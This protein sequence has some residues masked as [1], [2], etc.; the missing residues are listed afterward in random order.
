[1]SSMHMNM[2]HKRTHMYIVW[3]LPIHKKTLS[4]VSVVLPTRRLPVVKKDYSNS[5]LE[6]KLARV[7]QQESCE[8]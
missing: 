2:Y 4:L 7:W 1:M 5:A 8:M 3:E 6:F